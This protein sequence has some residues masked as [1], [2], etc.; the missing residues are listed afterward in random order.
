MRWKDRM[1]GGKADKLK[2]SMFPRRA[3]QRGTKHE[4]EHTNDWKRAME[5]AMDHLAE[6]ARYYYKLEKMERSSK[7]DDARVR[8]KIAKVEKKKAKLLKQLA[9]VDAVLDRLKSGRTRR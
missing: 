7:K 9:T 3:L 1:K 4:L 6:D 5:I 8:K 2:P